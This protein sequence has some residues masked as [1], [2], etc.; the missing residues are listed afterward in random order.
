MKRDKEQ[1]FVLHYYQPHKLDADQAI[2]CLNPR[3]TRRLRWV[4]V[5][6]SLLALAVFATVMTFSLSPTDRPTATTV[7]KSPAPPA[8]ETKTAA[9]TFHF[10]DTPVND[11]LRQLGNYYGVVLS[12]ND[13]TKHLT[14][15]F[16]SDDLNHTLRMI[17]EVLC[18]NIAIE[19]P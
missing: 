15:D 18:I 3:P 10:D 12:A 1:E 2:K 19:Q 7:S 14:G 5:A 16:C 8:Q 11:V 13:T 17:E 6:A 9:V 4:A